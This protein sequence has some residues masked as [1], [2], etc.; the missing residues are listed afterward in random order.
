MRKG[1]YSI[2]QGGTTARPT[3]KDTAM[4][5][6]QTISMRTR[7][8]RDCQTHIRR[9]IGCAQN[10][11]R[12]SW[13]MSRTCIHT[14]GRGLWR[15]ALRAHIFPFA[16]VYSCVHV[17]H[18][19]PRRR[20]RRRCLPARCARVNTHAETNILEN[21]VCQMGGTKC[22]LSCRT[23]RRRLC[24]RSRERPHVQGIPNTHRQTHRTASAAAASSSLAQVLA[25]SM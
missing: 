5:H 24:P 2:G 11:V 17:L 20:R 12:T 4:A 10:R 9:S 19:S 23:T 25:F 8:P 14:H 6:T 21:E 15:H 16:C 7:I 3:V 18:Y 13:P 22:T 1:C